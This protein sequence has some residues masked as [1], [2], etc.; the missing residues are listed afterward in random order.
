MNGVESRE[1][2]DFPVVNH[3]VEK[4]Q[5]E[6]VVAFGAEDLVES[7]IGDRSEPGG[8]LIEVFHS[9]EILVSQTNE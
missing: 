8:F 2:D 7:D 3:G 9:C 1:T 5:D 4:L 6:F